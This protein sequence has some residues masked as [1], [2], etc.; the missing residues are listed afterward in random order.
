MKEKKEKFAADWFAIEFTLGI[1]AIYVVCY[2]FPNNNPTVSLLSIKEMMLGPSPDAILPWQ[3]SAFFLVIIAA[4]SIILIFTVG[5]SIK[6]LFYGNK[7]SGILAVT[8]VVNMVAVPI[9]A[10]VY[11]NAFPSPIG[12]ALSLLASLFTGV[13]SWIIAILI[14][15]LASALGVKNFFEDIKKEALSAIEAER[16]RAPKPE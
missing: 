1:V 10:S 13:V 9:L 11:S 12:I 5:N 3:L 6:D 2:L 8:L 16:E 4:V 14:S 7:M 15:F